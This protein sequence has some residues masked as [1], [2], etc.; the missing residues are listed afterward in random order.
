MNELSAA[1][2][3]YLNR[4]KK[5]RLTVI[6]SRL[7]ILIGFFCLW[8]LCADKG[9][10]DS[11][12]FSS[13]SKIAVCF[14][15]MARDGSIF[16]HI[17]VTLYETIVSFLLVIAISVLMAVA[18]WLCPKLSEIL[19][20]YMVV[21]NSLPKSALAP[22]LILWLGATTT[23]IIVAGMSVAIFGSILNLYTA[24]RTV[25]PEKIKLIY[26]LRGT[27]LQAL[28]KAVIPSSIP[29]LISTMKVNIGLCLVGVIIGE[30]L[31]A[32]Q[33]LGYLII[34]ASQTFKLDW[35]LMSIVLLC[36]MAMLLYAV[37]NLL[38]RLYRRRMF[39][40]SSRRE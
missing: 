27:R 26:T 18:L 24:F 1:Q 35:L 2:L 32:R 36:L 31:A 28:T 29:A 40:S 11:F 17:G 14:L 19:D 8:E 20:P 30:F 39:D 34:Y 9:V 15:E 5:H 21:L 38:E 10:I 37:I 25:E 13:P 22:L 33:G 4:Q 7:A 16:L 12:I 23:T 3:R 6:L